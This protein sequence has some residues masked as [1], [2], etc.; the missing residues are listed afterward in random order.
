ML[1]PL[2]S[3]AKQLQFD[4]QK[5]GKNFSLSYIYQDSTKRV[6]EIDFA[7]PLK[8]IEASK[9]LLPSNAALNRAASDFLLVEGQQ[10][11][12]QYLLV[13]QASFKAAIAD[14]HSSIATFNGRLGAKAISMTVKEPQK[15]ELQLRL[16]GKD[17]LDIK[18][19]S[20]VPGIAFSRDTEAITKRLH[21]DV[22]SIVGLA[23]DGLPEGLRFVIIKK[24]DKI[25]NVSLKSDE[26]QYDRS[27][28]VTS[29]H[30]IS[31]TNARLRTRF[32]RH[33]REVQEVAKFVAGSK[34]RARTLLDEMS[35]RLSVARKEVIAE[36]KAKKIQFY[37]KHYLLP[38]KR[39]E[40]R[41]L[42][43]YARIAREARSR[44]HPIARAFRASTEG[45]DERE[46]VADI[47]HFFQSIPY[48]DLTKGH[49][50]G[51]KGFSPPLEMIAQ[52]FGDC[53]SKST[54]MMGLL[55]VLDKKRSVAIF[56]VPKHAF[57]GVEMEPR[58][59]DLFYTHQDKKYVLMEPTG[60]R[61]RPIGSLLK[62]SQKY[63]EE[64]R[65]DDIVILSQP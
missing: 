20:L 40:Q 9:N 16:A 51:F 21:T 32:A 1:A 39:N 65:V 50:R 4:T 48:N 11:A 28:R 24:G 31:A 45:K 38:S 10:T 25:T 37:A 3:A 18:V 17:L 15:L 63:L 61:L 41:T 54:A 43:D 42:I 64:G 47:L 36:L 46:R 56:L 33:K 35:Q 60:P 22:N 30:T 13:L 55:R 6:E 29:R 12:D 58:P 59:G 8:T 23:N 34:E 5:K 14:I 27:T 19:S 44:L 52:N 49:V 53:D 7:L 57:L 62:T 26:R 2:P